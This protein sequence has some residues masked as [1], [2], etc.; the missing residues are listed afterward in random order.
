MSARITP[1]G[2]EVLED[3]EAGD[4]V[5]LEP[6]LR[7]HVGSC[8]RCRAAFEDAGLGHIVALGNCRPRRS[9][10]SGSPRA[11]WRRSEPTKSG[12]R[13]VAAFSGARSNYLRAAC[14]CRG[15]SGNA[16]GFLRLRVCRAAGALRGIGQ[17]ISALVPQPEIQ[18]APQT[19]DDV[20]VLLAEHD[21]G[22]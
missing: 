10:V 20:L 17:E 5:S 9:P 12:E 4:Q 8:D 15:H 18:P 21:N 14:A 1:C 22:R 2:R 16:A 6:D 13:P 19:K 3:A 11:C 7:G